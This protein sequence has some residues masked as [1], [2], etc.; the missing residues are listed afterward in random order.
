MRGVLQGVW[1][2]G[3]HIWRGVLVVTLTVIALVGISAV[4]PDPDAHPGWA[5]IVGVTSGWCLG[6]G[7]VTGLRLITRGLAAYLRSRRQPIYILDL[8]DYG[9]LELPAGTTREE[10]ERRAER[11]NEAARGIITNRRKQAK[12]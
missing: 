3:R 5:L 4:F 11:L 6:I 12:P 7:M 10:A 9:Q 2:V 1:R 8:G